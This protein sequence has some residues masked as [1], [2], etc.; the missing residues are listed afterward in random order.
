LPASLRRSARF[1]GV[2]LGVVSEGVYKEVKLRSKMVGYLSLR[3]FRIGKKPQPKKKKKKNA[4]SGIS[5]CIF[6]NYV[7]RAFF[8]IVV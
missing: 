6:I 3:A 5:I 8:P 2:G 1:G 4:V 7:S